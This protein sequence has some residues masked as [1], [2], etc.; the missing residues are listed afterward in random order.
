MSLSIIFSKLALEMSYAHHNKLFAKLFVLADF[1]FV[2]LKLVC[3]YFG[4]FERELLFYF[5]FLCC[6][7]VFDCVV[8]DLLSIY[9][10]DPVCFTLMSAVCFNGF[11]IM[12]LYR[13]SS[14]L[15]ELGLTEY[16]FRVRSIMI[17]FCGAELH[18]CARLGIGVIIDHGVGIV[19]GGQVIVRNNVTIF[20]GVTLG[21][22]GNFCLGKRHPIIES[23]CFVGACCKVLGSVTLCHCVRV[24][25]NTV[26]SKSVLCYNTVVNVPA[27]LLI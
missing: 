2:L 21:G 24:S 11:K 23:G 12:F 6:V 5:S 15:W 7:K 18:P 17:V 20:H 26:V 3:S 4:L 16:A 10:R 19:I 13:L 8:V 9:L 27:R 1:R 25:A 22:T 14:F